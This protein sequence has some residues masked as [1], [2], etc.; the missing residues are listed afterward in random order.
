MRPRH[1]QPRNYF[2]NEHHEL[3]SEERRG[4]GQP[5]K[6][7][8]IDWATRSATVH[9]SLRRVADVVAQ[10]ADPT[11]ERRYYVV[12]VPVETVAKRSDNKKKAP[13]GTYD[14]VP[15]YSGPH[16]MVFRRLGVDLVGVHDDGR[17]TVHASRETFAQLLL[18]AKRLPDEGAREQARW[19]TIKEFATRTSDL[20]FDTSWL[21]ELP[22]QRPVDAVVELQPML[23]RFESDLV[24]RAL[25]EVLSAAE[26]ERFLGAGAHFSGRYWLKGRLSRR[27]I[28]RIASSYFSVQSIH[29]PLYS[30]A[31]GSRRAGRAQSSSATTVSPAPT[32]ADAPT[33][34]I[35][36]TGVPVD[37]LVLRGYSRGSR[38]QSPEAPAAFLG[39]HGSLVASR[40]V[41]GDVE[42]VGGLVPPSRG[43]CRFYDVMVASEPQR[44]DDDAVVRALQAVTATAPDVRLE[45]RDV[46]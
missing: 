20:V 15:E 26:D 5:P 42:M 37:H 35:V 4:G 40:V 34:A 25:A 30:A 38:Y 12:A 36:D 31:A 33:V 43:A 28:E 41:F 13:A 11:K 1:V 39:D 46:V 6:L 16:S 23:T 45:S 7:A 3:G 29:P 22:S 17:A 8:P 9:S 27:T 44:I 19:V 21:S 14:E 18:R 32:I 10:S 2:L 24:V